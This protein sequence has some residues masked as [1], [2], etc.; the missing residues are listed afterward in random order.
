MDKTDYF[1]ISQ[2][3]GLPSR[4]PILDYCKRRAL[5]IY[6]FSDFKEENR[7]N[8]IVQTLINAG[9]LNN[10]YVEKEI[11]LIGEAPL[12]MKGSGYGHFSNMCPE[13]SLFDSSNSIGYFAKTACTDASWEK[14]DKKPFKILEEKHYSECSEF[15]KYLFEN[16]TLTL[17]NIAKPKKTECYTYLMIDL[18]SGHH[19]IGI[20]S[21]PNYREKT[22]QSEQPKIETVIHRK[23]INRK[24]AKEFET[25]LHR[26]YDHKRIRGEWFNLEAKETSE[27]IQLM[28]E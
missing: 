21:D 26:K 15:S 24:L 27:I 4:C 9:E 12:I 19:K 23:F 17:K 8:D 18:K 28:Q 16:R 20:S 11:N 25:E 10:D 13:V 14:E 5:T 1:K 3:K 2:Q 6:H 22:L 7:T